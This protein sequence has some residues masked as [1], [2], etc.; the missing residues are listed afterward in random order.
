MR[1]RPDLALGLEQALVDAGA[2]LHEELL[3]LT[4]D[5]EREIN[6]GESGTAMSAVAY[7]ADVPVGAGGTSVDDGF[8]RLRGGASVER[9]RGRGVYR[10]VL[11]ARMAWAREHGADAAL[12]KGR[13][14]TSAPILRRAGFTAYGEERR[15]LVDA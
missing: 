4:R 8:A 1:A 14:D 2:R 5:D 13:V 7:L 9:A 15:Y 10:A 11:G 3:V 12:V 6:G